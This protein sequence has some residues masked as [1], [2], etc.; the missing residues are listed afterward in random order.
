[1]EPSDGSKA[2]KMKDFATHNVPDPSKVLTFACFATDTPKKSIFAA[3]FGTHGHPGLSGEGQSSSKLESTEIRKKM[4]PVSQK[5]G[6][7]KEMRAASEQR[8]I[9]RFSKVGS[10][11]LMKA[12]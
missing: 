7:F 2:L 8:T 1:M 11:S 10:L 6:F 12:I 9:M 3:L 5:M 4:N